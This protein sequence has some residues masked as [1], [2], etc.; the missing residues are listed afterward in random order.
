VG[1]TGISTVAITVERASRSDAPA[2][3][4]F[5]EQVRLRV[6]AEL[7]QAM[8]DP[9]EL[10][11]AVRFPVEGRTTADGVHVERDRSNMVA[12]IIRDIHIG[13]WMDVPHAETPP[14][15]EL[16]RETIALLSKAIA[17]H[18]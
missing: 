14:L 15:V 9:S 10:L 13:D 16:M 18:Q 12:S 2:T 11:A 6:V 7:R 5:D 8:S 17:L 1:H 4:L 3:K